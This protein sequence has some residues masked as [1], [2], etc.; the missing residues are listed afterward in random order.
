MNPSCTWS[1]LSAALNGQ[2]VGRQSGSERAIS[3]VRA[4]FVNDF[5]QG[6]KINQWCFDASK[7]NKPGDVR[8]CGPHIHN[9]LLNKLVFT[10]LDDFW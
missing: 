3:Y 6:F 1:P 4:Q 10:N 2:S 9:L 8:I 5:L 7:S